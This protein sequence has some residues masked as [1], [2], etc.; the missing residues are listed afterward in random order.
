MDTEYKE[1]AENIAEEFSKFPQVVAIALGGS[2]IQGNKVTDRDS[3]IDIYVYTE[4]DIP[5][6]LREDLVEKTG[7]SRL[8]DMGLDY[9]G[10][11]DE[12]INKPSNIEIDIVYFD[13]SWMKKEIDK[14][15]V[16]NQSNI[17]YTTCFWYTVQKS[18]IIYDPAKWFSELQQK[19]KIDYPDLLRKNIV[20]KNY[21]ILG[22]IIPSYGNQIRKAVKR[23]DL[24]S[25]NHRTTAFCASYFDI[26]FA[27]N[28][29]L[30]PGEKRLLDFAEQNCDSLPQNMRKDIESIVL[31][32]ESDISSIPQK[33]EKILNR[34]EKWLDSE[35]FSE[36]TGVRD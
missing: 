24:I 10:P 33:L 15:V 16:G 12:W 18:I 31:L 36:L 6:Y 5:I 23:N 25:I 3:D 17:G 19:A 30:H 21:P 4:E 14:V 35:G 29:L 1:L 27:V 2:V 28:R 7:G 8:K 22:K 13:T 34:L 20:F 26:I 9:W 32:K 11:G